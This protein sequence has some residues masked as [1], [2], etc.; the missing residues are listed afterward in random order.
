MNIDERLQEVSVIG[1]AGKM[2]SGIAVLIAS[3]MAA[4]RE[5]YPNRFFKLNLIDVDEEGLVGLQSYMRKQ[6]TKR[7]E[8][9]IN[10]VRELY[11]DREDLV[12]NGEMI[13]N[14]IFEGMS[15]CNFTTNLEDAK[16]SNVIF[17]AIAENIGTKVKVL[18]ILKN[19]CAEE[20]LYLTNTSSVPISILDEEVG[21]NGKII[22]Y[23]FYNP[24]VIQR[25]VEVITNDNTDEELKQFA[26]ELGERLQKKLVPANDISGFIGNGH[27]A[28]DG[29]HALKKVEKLMGEGYSY[30]EAVYIINTVSQ[31][32]LLRPMG[33][34]Q[35]IDYVGVDVFKAIYDIMSE[36]IP[37]PSL[38]SDLLDK[39]VAKG[40]QGGQR[41]D[42]T[43]VD[44][45]LQYQKNRPI[46]VYDIANEDY[47]AIR[48]GLKEKLTEYIGGTPEGWLPWKGML[49]D[50]KKGEKMGR[51]FAN[52]RKMDTMGAELAVEYLDNS[53]QIG[54]KLVEQGVAD[55]AKEVN[56]VLKNGF[57]HLYGPINDY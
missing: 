11:K 13:E 56:D 26:A 44:G 2:G 57:F 29:L 32:F 42:G 23:H 45:F 27:F 14:F 53:K 25:L 19:L 10:F 3:E 24:P 38:E 21:L 43:Q 9:T 50:P 52:L 34:F 5:K 7:A 8:K 41:A 39:I 1:A 36:H 17:E 35:L 40:V 33:I 54:H 28:R 18:S 16:N 20:T 47:V 30:P 4:M 55:S 12:E 22:G 6:L 48:D 49:V 15:P 46:G 51:Y 37:D 31:K